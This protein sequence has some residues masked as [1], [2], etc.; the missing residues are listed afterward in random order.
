MSD[1][2]GIYDP[3]TVIRS[4]PETPEYTAAMSAFGPEFIHT[5]ACEAVLGQDE[6]EVQSDRY[7][8]TPSQNSVI[9]IEVLA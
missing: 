2:I 8:R 1:Y 7:G 4:I 6:Y 3:E 5:F 9:R